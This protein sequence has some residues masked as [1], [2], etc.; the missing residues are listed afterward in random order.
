MH[1]TAFDED[2]HEQ[3]RS[4]KLIAS[5]VVEPAVPGLVGHRSKWM[6]RIDEHGVRH[7]SEVRADG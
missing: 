4:D 3:G 2:S 5:G 6:L 7:E 1:L